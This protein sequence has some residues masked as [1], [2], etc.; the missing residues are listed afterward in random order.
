M[1]DDLTSARAPRHAKRQLTS[2]FDSTQVVL[3]SVSL[4]CLS[5]SSIVSLYLAAL[6]GHM[7]MSKEKLWPRPSGEAYRCF[8]VGLTQASATALRSVQSKPSR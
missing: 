1:A 4:T 6:Y 3:L 5:D 8:R 2:W 7:S